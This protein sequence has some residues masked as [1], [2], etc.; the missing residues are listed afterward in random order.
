MNYI[1][2]FILVL[3]AWAIFRGITRGLIKQFSSLAALLLGIYG[4][5]KLSAYTAQQLAKYFDLNKEFLYLAAIAITFLIV[6]ILV[7]L[8]GKL[9]DK[10]IG[11][12]EMS[13]A[14]KILGVIF[15]LG[16][17][18][19][20]VGIILIYVDRIDQRVTI[21]PKYSRENSI[22][23]K[24]FTSIVQMIFPIFE[25]EKSEYIKNEIIV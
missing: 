7:N 5:L 11:S 16:K 1:D 18:I 13:F 10:M 23:F 25:K 8:L 15:S 19:L 3:L 24:P 17:T 4:A 20:I 21:L 9:L 14:N 12:T 22:F 6:F 2:M